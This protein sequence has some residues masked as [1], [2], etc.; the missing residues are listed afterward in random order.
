MFEVKDKKWKYP[1]EQELKDWEILENEGAF[2]CM[3]WL[4][5][6]GYLNIG[7]VIKE[8]EVSYDDDLTALHYL[9]EKYKNSKK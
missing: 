8:L 5:Q 3:D 6:N 1:T 2:E 9:K 4:F 7:I